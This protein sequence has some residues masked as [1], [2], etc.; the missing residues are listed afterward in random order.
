MQLTCL[1]HPVHGMIVTDDENKFNDLIAS[2]L[3]FDHPNKAKDMEN[4]LYEE[5]I[6]SKSRKRRSDCKRQTTSDGGDAQLS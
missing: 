5:P 1:Y 2:G 3:W 4:K 6:R